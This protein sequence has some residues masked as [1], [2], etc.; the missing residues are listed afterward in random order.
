MI[1]PVSGSMQKLTST[2]VC[3]AELTSYLVGLEVEYPAK[4]VGI[5]EDA[6]LLTEVLNT[7]T[8]IGNGSNGRTNLHN[9]MPEIHVI[10]LR[11]VLL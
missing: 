4:S 3:V 2:C 11:I 7:F 9:S 6:E 8:K 10:T 1:L 5:D